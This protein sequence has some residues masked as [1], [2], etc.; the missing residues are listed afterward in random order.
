[1]NQRVDLSGIFGT[2]SPVVGMVHALP[3]PGSPGYGG[4]MDDVVSQATKD[5]R[6]LCEGG[7]H[8]IIVENFGDMPFFAE[9]VPPETVAALSIVVQEARKC[10]EGPVGVNVLRNDARSAVALAAVTEASFVR[11]NVH[12][13]TMWTDQGSICGRACETLRLRASLTPDLAILA[14]VFV[15]HATPPPGLP[16][17]EAARDTWTRG[18]AD[19]L[20]VSGSGTGSPTSMEHVE[21]VRAAVPEAPVWVGSGVTE[22]S[23]AVVSEMADGMIVGSALQRDGIAGN[24]VD[25]ARVRAFMARVGRG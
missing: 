9:R 21:H 15:K 14:D 22:E 16:L 25:E 3:L 8:G 7:V 13:G 4:S 18:L 20:I 24:A 23:A 2:E 11:I 1:M 12:V 10:F 5:A 17:E 19:G 6:A